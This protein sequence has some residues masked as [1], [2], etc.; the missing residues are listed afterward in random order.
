[1]IEELLRDEIKGFKNYEVYNIPC[2][3]KM[4]ANETP[5]K[6]PA[7]VM[8]NIKEIISFANVN[9]YPDPV[10][11]KLKEELSKYCGVKLE[12]IMIGNGSDELIHLIILAFVDKNDV[13]L[14][15]DPSFS[16][17]SVYTKM[18]GALEVSVRLNEDYSYNVVRFV[19]AIKK[20][21]PKV[22]FLCTPNNPTGSIIKRDDILKIVDV[23]DGLVVVDEAYY[24]F[25]GKTVVD[26]VDKYDNVI[27]L[28]TL[29]KAFGL[30]G[31]RVG[32]LVANK[33]AVKCL[34]LVK[35]PYNTNSVSQAI[36]LNVLRSG[37][38]KD[39]LD[40]ILNERQYLVNELIEIGGVKVYPSNANFILV[41]FKD[42][43]YVYNELIKRG[44]LVRN[45]SKSPNLEGC[46]RITVGTRESNNYLLQCLREMLV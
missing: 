37:T 36:A 46:L 1:M 24:E 30:A 2:K 6:L 17:Y 27:V 23:S 11:E 8:E 20:Y 38:L 15:P 25:Y 29:S 34:S 18:A 41:K 4:D 43:D 32:Y 33:T 45:F 21:K 3:Y 16:M 39:R 31:L 40:Y 10:A 42:A 26:I 7:T 12:N 35:P 14:Y 28:R 22:V 13:V 44:I 9:I 5:F 19:E